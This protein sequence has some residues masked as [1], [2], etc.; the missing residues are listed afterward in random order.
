M[1]EILKVAIAD[2]EPEVR[3]YFTQAVERMGHEVPIVVGNGRELLERCRQDRPD[4]IITDIRMDE[5]DGIAAISEL[6]REGPIPS[7][8]ISAHYIPEQIEPAIQPFV[9]AFLTK[10]VKLADLN[11]VVAEAVVRLAS[12][13]DP[14]KNQ[15]SSP[16]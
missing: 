11:A 5:L 16:P 15:T 6:A 7:I 1:A 9:V 13:V 14:T 4:L 8:V 2:D 12:Q 10:P 3:Q